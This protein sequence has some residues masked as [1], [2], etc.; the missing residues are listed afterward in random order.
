MQK[1]AYKKAPG[2]STWGFFVCIGPAPFEPGG[3]VPVYK[4]FDLLLFSKG[5]TRG[6]TVLAAGA[7][8]ARFTLAAKA[9]EVRCSIPDE[10]YAVLIN[11]PPVQ[12]CGHHHHSF[13]GS[14]QEWPDYLAPHL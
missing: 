2:L 9:I 3:N 11:P 6:Y 8:L 4:W 1:I 5:Y 13:D 7:F 14:V 10:R 12:R